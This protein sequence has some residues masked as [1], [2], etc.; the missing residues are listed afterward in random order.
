MPEAQQQSDSQSALIRFM[1][2]FKK[3]PNDP[4]EKGV[5]EEAC[6][7]V[8]VTCPS[9]DVAREIS[10]AVVSAKRVACVNVIPGLTSI[11]EW[12]GAICEESEVLLVMKAQE[13][14][15]EGLYQQLKSIHPY[16]VP[17][18]VVLPILAGNESYIHWLRSVTC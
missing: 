2:S 15:L 6:C 18:F 7:V 10:K 3:D 11:Y 12:D 1:A 4:L 16:T 17:E 8:L 9:V 14:H 13:R 5:S